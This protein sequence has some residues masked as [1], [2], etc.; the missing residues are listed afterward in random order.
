MQRW[1]DTG[2]DSGWYYSDPGYFPLP[3]GRSCTYRPVT[4]PYAGQTIVVRPGYGPLVCFLLVVWLTGGYVS[5]GVLI[6]VSKRRPRPPFAPWLQSGP[7]Q[8]AR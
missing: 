7:V 8:G 5:W 2:L 4:G 1:E 6:F 3:I